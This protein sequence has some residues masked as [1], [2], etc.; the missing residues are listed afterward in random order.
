MFSEGER[1]E[2]ERNVQKHAKP[3][4]YFLEEVSKADEGVNQ[5]GM[6]VRGKK[7]RP[8]KYSSS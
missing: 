4:I 6:N 7:A 8:E 2:V 5:F 1:E 3:M